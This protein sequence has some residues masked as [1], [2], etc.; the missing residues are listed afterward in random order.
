ML[1]G[2]KRAEGDCF[3][4]TLSPV[5]LN[6]LGAPVRLRVPSGKMTALLWCF[7]IY[8][9]SF[10]SSPMDCLGSFLSIS[11]EPPCRRLK[12]TLGMPLPSSSL[13]TNFGWY[14]LIYQMMGG[15]SY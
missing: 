11:A 2:T 3:I 9:P 8:C 1:I 12:E 6:G 4:K 13:L 5:V 10:C 7:S 14:F 15:I